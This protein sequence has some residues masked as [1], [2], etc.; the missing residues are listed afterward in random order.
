M[1]AI[2]IL[3][4]FVFWLLVLRLVLRSVAAG[5]RR[6]DAGPGRPATGGAEELIRDPLCGT[7]VPRSRALAA[8]IGSEDALFCSE[9]CR[10][11]ARAGVRP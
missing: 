5:F 2:V 7:Y 9:A 10:Q 6:T 1:R 4:Q 8:R 3:V 11:R